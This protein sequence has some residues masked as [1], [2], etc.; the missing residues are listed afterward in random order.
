MT[1]VRPVLVRQIAVALVLTLFASLTLATPAAAADNR[2]AGQ[3]RDR[4]EYLI[5]RQRIRRGMRRLRVNVRTFHG[6]REHA[7]NMAARRTIYHDPN[8]RNEIPNGCYAWAENVG[9]T[10]SSDAAKSA[11]TM[12]MNSSAH[13]S[14]ILSKRMTHMGIGVA[15]RGNYAYVAQRF[16]DRR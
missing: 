9:R 7:G 15:K 12:F 2:H 5:N 11:M 16:I 8:L 13:R 6:A 14:N 10:S 1:V 3:I 4:I